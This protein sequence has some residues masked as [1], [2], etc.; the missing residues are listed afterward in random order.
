MAFDPT[1]A[2]PV[3]QGFDPTTAKLSEEE[4]KVSVTEYLLNAAKL[5]LTDTAVIGESILD[6]FVIDPI[7][8]LVTGNVAT[9][10]ATTIP[11]RW[12]S[13]I[14][15]LSESGAAITGADPYLQAPDPTTRTLGSG[16]RMMSDPVGYA[17]APVKFSGLSG[18]AFQLGSAGIAAD[19]GGE[20]GA[21]AEKK[22]TGE[23]T[24]L[25]RTVGSLSGVTGTFAVTA[26]TR[27]A[28]SNV[29]DV[30]GK[31]TRVVANKLLN[32][33]NNVKTDPS[34][35]NIAYSSGAA[36]KL[37]QDIAKEDGIEN[38]E[39][40]VTNFNRIGNKID[41][42]NMP[43]LVA[44]SESPVVSKEVRRLAKANPE[45]RQQ[46]NNE[47]R[48]LTNSI[49]RYSENIFGTRYAKIANPGQLT[50]KMEGDLDT[51]LKRRQEIDTRIQ[52]YSDRLVP[53]GT[54]EQRGQAIQNL[55][56][57]REKL[58]RKEVSPLYDQV[59]REATEANVKMPSKAVESIYNY[60]QE[61]NIRDLF[62]KNTSLDNKI[63]GLLKPRKVQIEGTPATGD[64]FMGTYRAGTPTTTVMQSPELTFE[65]VDSL[66]R[67]INELKRKPL[68]ATEQRQL[69]NLDEVIRNA[70]NQIPGDFSQRLSKVDMLY[71]ERVGIPFTEQ[72][73]KEISAKK[74]AEQVAPVIIKNKSALDDFI[75]VTGNQG[76][77]VARNAMYADVY[78]KA[79]VNGELNIK[80][81]QNYMK[82]NKDVINSIPGMREDLNEIIANHGKLFSEKGRLDAA[83]KLE[84]K[85]IADH[86]LQ[87]SQA[88]T[89]YASTAGV[90]YSKLVN[91]MM[92]NKGLI[93]KINKDVSKLDYETAKAV[94]GSIRSE[95]VTVA[96]NKPEGA[97]KYLTDPKN[98][99]AVEAI[100]GKGYIKA[101]KDVA[102]L[103]D[104]VVNSDI[105][106]IAYTNEAKEFSKI[107]GVGLPY[108]VSQ[109]RDRI[110]SNTQ[111][112]VRIMSKIWE[113]GRGGSADDAVMELL[114]NPDGLK[115]LEAVALEVANK[116]SITANQLNKIKNILGDY[117]PA[118]IYSSAKLEIMP[119]EPT[120]MTEEQ[121]IQY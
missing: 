113:A 102:R 120:V 95:L 48:I 78:K 117:M 50:A 59:I 76:Y 90:D 80:S 92:R 46:V 38:I 8:A 93:D 83:Y 108:Y 66:K 121:R 112:A 56:N 91:D 10:K 103:S 101:A 69:S 41:K 22:L 37:L 33:F 119:K 52:Q 24:G 19:I 12:G 65:Q 84:Q 115:K 5:G 7:T 67:S 118:Y 45:F 21:E 57:A 44:L 110:S 97:F 111:K 28:A 35:L 6:T 72:G 75:N 87:T 74:Y 86:F 60:V 53:V 34:E 109:I 1:T 68:S 39:E 18:R 42:R 79:V 63:M 116:P 14:Q 43:I 32:K 96:R 4:P 73:I 100:M 30:T 61:N 55:V 77:Q 26:P 98:A 20:L 105:S 9:D 49:D 3:S 40:I 71:Y 31:T 17:A 104:A 15:R 51:V 88:T 70:R 13:N 27:L 36:K 62:G 2:R 107:Q 64:Y 81:L 85:K 23:D 106:K 82:T 16:V 29:I 47:L 114:M 54:E 94:R 89:S 25:G 11:E 99:A 58:A